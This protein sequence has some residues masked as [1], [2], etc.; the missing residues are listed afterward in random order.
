M[1]LS[2]G[3]EKEVGDDELLEEEDSL[4]GHEHNDDQEEDVTRM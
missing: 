2:H 4:R 1:T 3:E